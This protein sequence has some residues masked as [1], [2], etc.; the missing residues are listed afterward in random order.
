L[1]AAQGLRVAN[2]FHAGDGNL[3]PLILYDGSQDGALARAEELARKK[4]VLPINI[5]LAYVL[6]QPFPTFAIIGPRVLAE[7]R[8][9]LPA[10]TVTLTPEEVRWLNLED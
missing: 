3:H 6:N 10:V 4:G 1:G 2:V 7:T 8:T 5:A 9:S